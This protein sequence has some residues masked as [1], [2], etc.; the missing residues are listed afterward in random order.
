MVFCYY[1]Q[2]S[3]MIGRVDSKGFLKAIFFSLAAV[4]FIYCAA[5]RQGF[6]FFDNVDLVVHEAGHVLFFP[7]GEFLNVAGGTIL[8]LLAPMVFVLYFLF[9]RDFYSV[10]IVSFWLGQSFVNVARYAADAV[11]MNLSLLGGGNHDWNFLLAQTGALAEAQTVSNAFYYA[12]IAIICAGIIIGL[13][14]IKYHKDGEGQPGKN[15]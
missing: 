11:E 5:D 12:G 13:S 14:N 15:N 4:Y 2:M 8:Q 6:H 10:G 9:K 3:T 7:F 1:G